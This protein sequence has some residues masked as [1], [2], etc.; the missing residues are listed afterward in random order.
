MLSTI[1]LV[2][3][4]LA[5]LSPWLVTMLVTQTPQ[6][7]R[8]QEEILSS[9]IILILFPLSTLTH[10][11]LIADFTH[12]TCLGLSRVVML[13]TELLTSKSLTL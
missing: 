4:L 2:A 1:T 5:I 11:S 6:F 13:T 3:I 8:D 7:S 10:F 9:G 12:C